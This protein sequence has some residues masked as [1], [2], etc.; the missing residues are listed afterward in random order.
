MESFD[1]VITSG[2]LDMSAGGRLCFMSAGGDFS[3]VAVADAVARDHMSTPDYRPL[4]P[5]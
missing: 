1:I 3:G 2:N 4:L 5:R